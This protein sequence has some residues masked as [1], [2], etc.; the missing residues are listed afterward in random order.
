MWYWSV[1][2]SVHYVALCEEIFAFNLDF[3]SSISPV[4]MGDFKILPMIL[5]DIG[6]MISVS[7]QVKLRESFSFKG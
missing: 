1:E 6:F 3:L 7:F 4:H 2:F 5:K